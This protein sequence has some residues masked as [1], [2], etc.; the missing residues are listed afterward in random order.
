MFLVP[1][2]HYNLPRTIGFE[3]RISGVG[4][5]RS[6]LQLC[7]AQS[8]SNR[9]RNFSAYVTSDISSDGPLN[10]AKKY[11]LTCLL[12]ACYSTF[13]VVFVPPSVCLF[14]FPKYDAFLTCLA[15][16]AP[17]SLTHSLLLLLLP[18][19]VDLEPQPE[20]KYFCVRI[21]LFCF[22]V[23]LHSRKGKGKAE[24]ARA[25]F[26]V[27]MKSQLRRPY[28]CDQIGRF[29]G[30]WATFQSLWRQLIG[31]NLLHSKAIFV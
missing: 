6:Y 13:L 17:H 31:P 5:N 30:L 24:R 4:S 21:N 27:P 18:D 23:L 19:V 20:S 14:V 10:C 16:A 22:K 3:P 2:Q 26:G 25:A 7:H 9:W 28:Q 8:L 11:L 12:P 29:M 15:A 1:S